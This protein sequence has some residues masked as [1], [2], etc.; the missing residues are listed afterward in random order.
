MRLGRRRR[1][2]LN[3]WQGRLLSVHA[4][5]VTVVVAVVL[6]AA[7][8]APFLG[9]PTAVDA[10]QAA[11]KSQRFWVGFGLVLGL[12]TLHAVMLTQR[13]AGSW[14]RILQV[15]RRVQDGDLT[16]RVVLRWSDPLQD[17]REAVNQMIG[18]LDE[19]AFNL[20][21]SYRGAHLALGDLVAALNHRDVDHASRI[22]GALGGELDRM[23]RVLGQ[24]RPSREPDPLPA[25]AVSELQ[26][27]GNGKGNGEAKS[28]QPAIIGGEVGVP[29]EHVWLR[30]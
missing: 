21:R 9:G 27:D 25:A 16:R 11:E 22:A 18:S 15:I 8:G 14:W 10:Q 30:R 3:G 20:H 7:M 4:F 28:P 13:L 29:E 23:G 26:P 17:E 19:K 2:I 12:L 1:F 6:V 24:L 5:Y